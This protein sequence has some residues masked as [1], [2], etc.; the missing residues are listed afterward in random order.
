MYAELAKEMQAGKIG[1]V[2]VARAYRVSN[3]SPRRASASTP[4]RPR[5]RS[6]IGTCGSARA[7]ASLQGQHRPVQIPLVA[8]VLVAGGQLGRPLLRRDPLGPERRGAGLDLGPRRPVRRGRRPHHPGHDGGDLRDCL[9]ACCWS[10]GST[11]RTGSPPSNTA[12]SSSGAR[13]AIS[14]PAPKAAGTR[15]S[16]RRA[17][18]SSPRSRASSPRR[19]RQTKAGRT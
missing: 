15:S 8:G 11:K 4:T 16:P 10:S 17:G 2:T 13:S 6:W 9:P 12:R 1:K 14:T 5:P 18:S 7:A 3:M 19:N